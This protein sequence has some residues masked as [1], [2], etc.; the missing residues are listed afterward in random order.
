MARFRLVADP[1]LL[2]EVAEQVA[3]VDGADRLHV[4]VVACA[5][6]AATAVLAALAGADLVLACTAPDEVVDAL[7]DDLWHLGP[8][9]HVA[10]PGVSLSAEQVALL[11]RLAAGESLGEAAAGLHLSRRTADRRLAQARAA[12]DVRT[13]A[14]AVVVATRRGL[15]G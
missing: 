8:V 9:E 10:A 5:E 13:T 4:A 7:V 6:D 12:L 1:D 2:A 11:A 14:E 15:V 3:R